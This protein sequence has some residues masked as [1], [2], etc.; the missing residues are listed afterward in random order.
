MS[1]PIEFKTHP[2]QTEWSSMDLDF[3]YFSSDWDKDTIYSVIMEYVFTDISSDDE[4]Y[5]ENCSVKDM[6]KY[7]YIVQSHF[8]DISLLESES[9]YEAL[10]MERGS[11]FD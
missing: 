10:M 5:E 11:F 6:E 8:K 3:D 2:S 7:V 1:F 9:K 4:D